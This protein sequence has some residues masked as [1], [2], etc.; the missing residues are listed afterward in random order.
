MQRS[1]TAVYEVVS[2][3]PLVGMHHRT[4]TWKKGSKAWFLG[5]H[6]L[7]SR[8]SLSPGEKGQ[9]NPRYQVHSGDIVLLPLHCSSSSSSSNSSSSCPP[10][11]DAVLLPASPTPPPPPSAPVPAFDSRRR[12]F[13]SLRTAIL[14]PCE[15]SFLDNSV[16]S[17]I[18]GNRRGVYTAVKSMDEETS[19]RRRGRR[20]MSHRTA[21]CTLPQEP[22]R[23]LRQRDRL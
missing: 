9:G 1:K 16:G 22:P 11:C 15:A 7:V 20:K 8:T 12:F 6:E 17:I 4:S 23:P 10:F 13:L 21:P 5:R 3:V 18:P 14:M 19:M 2:R